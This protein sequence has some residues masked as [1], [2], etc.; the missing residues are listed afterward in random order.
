MSVFERVLGKEGKA[1]EALVLS[2]NEAF[3]VVAIGAIAADGT[4]SED[5]ILRT[6]INLA[7]LPGFRTMDFKEMAEVLNRAAAIVKRRG[8][9]AVMPVAKEALSK[10]QAEQA[11]FLAADLVL[12]D[13]AVEKDERLFLEEL[14]GFLGVDESTALKI[15][16]VVIIKNRQA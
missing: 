5:E 16:E 4:I 6:A 10:E 1:E 15:V 8:V 14:R 13:G 7:S 11:L 12:S 9:S 3:A 2:K